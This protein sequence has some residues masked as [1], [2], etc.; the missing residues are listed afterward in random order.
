MCGLK[1]L[2]NLD[3]MTQEERVLLVLCT[4]LNQKFKN[5]CSMSLLYMQFTH[6]IMPSQLTHISL[7]EWNSPF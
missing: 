7:V 1:K 3:V 4:R 2:M 6:D 5:N